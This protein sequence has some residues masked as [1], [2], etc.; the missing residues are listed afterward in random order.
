MLDIIQRLLGSDEPTIRF[1]VRVNV[2][3]EDPQSDS[4]RALQENIRA[5]PRVQS[6]LSER[7]ADGKIP[8]HPYAKWYGAHWVLA[9]LADLG[10]PPGDTSLIP[11]REQVLDCWLSRHHITSVRVIQGRARRCA[12]QEGNALY[13]LIALG[14]ADE[15]ADQLARNLLK[16]QWTDGGWNCD[17]KPEAVNSSYHESLLPLRALALYG[18]HTGCREVLEAVRRAAEVFLKRR[19][20]RRQRDGSVI[21]ERFTKLHYPAYWHY[22]VLAA[23]KV[24]AEAGFIGDE[25]CQEALDLLESKRLSDGGFPAEERLYRVTNQKTATGRS[26]SLVNWGPVSQRQMNEFVTADALT[27]LKAAGRLGAKP[28]KKEVFR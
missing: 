22:D 9:T 16:W 12:S 1:K 23:L 26:A 10:Y 6:L 5:S 17:K 14:L 21:N 7:G 2:L 28:H 4:I 27:V 24:M 8:Y 15:R 3:G 13:A 25:R 19:L 11:L 18:K 20:F